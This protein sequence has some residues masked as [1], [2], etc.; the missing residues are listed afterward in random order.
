MKEGL[1]I[2]ASPVFQP[3]QFGQPFGYHKE[4]AKGPP[5]KKKAYGGKGFKS[6]RQSIPANKKTDGII[7]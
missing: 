5:G 6:W 1:A 3:A 4:M 2:K 7:S